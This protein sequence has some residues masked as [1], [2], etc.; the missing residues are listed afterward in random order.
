MNGN[1][2]PLVSFII[3][4]YNTAK[5][6][7]RAI[8][9]VL[10]Q[11]YTNIEVVL[12]DDGSMD[13]SE[14]ICDNYAKRDSRFKVIH[15]NNSGVSVARNM[16]I[17]NASGKYIQFVDSDDEIKKEMTETLVN[18]ME[19]EKC[20]IA[21]CGYSNKGRLTKEICSETRLYNRTE[22]LVTSYVNEKISPL[23]WGTCNMLFK[24]SVLLNK[25]IRFD[26][27]FAMGE[28]GLFTLAYLLQIEKIFVINRILYDYYLYEPIERVSAVSH[29]SP[30]VY[31]LRIHYF[32]QLFIGLKN[33]IKKQEEK[34]LLQTFHDKLIAGLVRLGA[35]SEDISNGDMEE[36]LKFVLHNKLV[37]QASKV[38]TRKRR[39]DSILIPLFIKWKFVRLLYVALK[40]KGKK[41]ISK[42]GKRSFIQSVY[43][44]MRGDMYE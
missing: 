41:Y 21:I 43:T 24:H 6:V 20:D 30:D 13:G 9:S 8:D 18:T 11:S 27:T 34:L 32:N 38:Y 39:G 12:I 28:D 3:P 23:V 22:F 17:E 31:E 35:Y 10:A 7:G 19:R 5:F 36:R 29:I 40:I 2:K 1:D 26:S 25:K 33:D 4:V 44:E 42:Y 16:G 37:E 15:Q 14:D